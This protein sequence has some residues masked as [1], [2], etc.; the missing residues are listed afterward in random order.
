[1]IIFIARLMRPVVEEALRQMH[2]ERADQADA[3]SMDPLERFFFMTLG[4][5][6]L[7]SRPPFQEPRLSCEED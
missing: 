5:E 6:P 2:G 3:A 7:R 1:M 4:G